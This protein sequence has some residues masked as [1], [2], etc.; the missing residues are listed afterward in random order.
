MT[1]NDPIPLRAAAEQLRARVMNWLRY[2]PFT[3]RFYWLAKPN[4]RIRVGAAAGKTRKDGYVVIKVEGKY[5]YAHQLVFLVMTGAVP[6][7]ID[8]KNRDR[9]DNRFEN[10]RAATPTQSNANT[11]KRTGATST[12]KGVHWAATH[13]LWRARI[14]V[15]GKYRSLGYFK[16]EQEAHEAYKAAAKDA[17]GEFSSIQ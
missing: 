1:D 13:M 9:S 15:A 5:F 8:H 12:L 4:N 7:L 10:L 2:D 17:F 3:G 16:T 6:E 14:K 11:A